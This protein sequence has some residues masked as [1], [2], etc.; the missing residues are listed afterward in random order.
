[1]G[2]RYT[3][4]KDGEVILRNVKPYKIRFIYSNDGYDV[5]V[6]P[7]IKDFKDDVLHEYIITVHVTDLKEL[8]HMINVLE[9]VKCAFEGT[10][11]TYLLRNERVEGCDIQ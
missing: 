6:S 3:I 8:E 10:L 11:D 5:Y 9:K 4:K 7:D 2:V 1:M